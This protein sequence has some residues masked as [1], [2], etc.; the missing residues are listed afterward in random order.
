MF[1]WSHNARGSLIIC[2]RVRCSAWC[3]TKETQGIIQQAQQHPPRPLAEETTFSIWAGFGKS[4]FAHQW[5]LQKPKS[6]YP[7]PSPSLIW[8]LCFSPLFIVDDFAPRTVP[9]AQP[10]SNGQ[11]C[12]FLGPQKQHLGVNHRIKFQVTCL[13]QMVESAKDGSMETLFAG[14]KESIPPWCD[15]LTVVRK[16]QCMFGCRDDCCTKCIFG[17]FSGI[18]TVETP[19][20]KI[21]IGDLRLGDNVLTYTPEKGT[22]YTE[23]KENR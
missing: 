2:F 9:G 22:H 3:T 11:S 8:K 15:H 7:L 12:P 17:C 4:K 6:W 16:F 19:R 18:S 5:R 14:G 13:F 1:L 23:V 20:G 21:P 10:P